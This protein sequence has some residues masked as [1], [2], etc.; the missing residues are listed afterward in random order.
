MSRWW[1]ILHCFGAFTVGM[2]SVGA[3]GPVADSSSRIHTAINLLMRVPSGR[4]L[5]T[6]ALKAWKMDSS[7]SLL[8]VVKAGPAS[9]TDAVLTRHY[10][11]SSGEEVR[12]REITIYVRQDQ[13]LDNVVLDIAH[14]MVHATSRPGWDP[15]DPELTAGRYIKNSIEG[16]GGEVQAVTTE[17]QVASE[18]ST[19]YGFATR[20]C[21]G[22]IGG[23]SNHVD[24]EKIRA[25]FYRVGKWGGDLAKVLGTEIKLFPK[26]S[27]D[28][29]KLYSSTGNAPYPAALLR[30]F[31]QLTQIACENSK[32][33]A[34]SLRGRSLASTNDAG[35]ATF[36]FLER[37]CQ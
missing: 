33:R 15:Y 26:L 7:E 14:E 35:D 31:Q 5:I 28:A 24:V 11:P 30:E 32:R 9:R 10:N 13:S 20:R 3:S 16:E 36:R 2:L 25:D 6:H 34:D 21:R 19:Y 37:R 22:Y 27:S 17:C 23:N 12:E 1:A 4:A 29:P 18:L 8:K